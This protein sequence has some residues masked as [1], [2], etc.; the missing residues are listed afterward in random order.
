MEKRFCLQAAASVKNSAVQ[1]AR[2]Q[3]ER[4][5]ETSAAVAQTAY[6]SI[7]TSEDGPKSG[8]SFSPKDVPGDIAATS[9][10]RKIAR[11]VFSMRRRPK[12]LR[13]TSTSRPVSNVGVRR[14]STTPE[15]L[16]S[17]KKNTAR[18]LGPV[19]L[20][21]VPVGEMHV[22]GDKIAERV[23]DRSASIKLQPL[24]DVRVMTENDRGPGIDEL[25]RLLDLKRRR[26]PKR[27]SPQCTET[28]TCWT[29]PRRS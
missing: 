10:P 7:S 4:A 25:M 23:N 17:A 21:H 26:R 13:S 9:T 8:G 22:V 3:P 19:P 29:C 11:P 5:Y 16:S 1:R 15:A 14:T 28:M 20:H 12:P 2:G 27:S 6:F 18:S 24:Q